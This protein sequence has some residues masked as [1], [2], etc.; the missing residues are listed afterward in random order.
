MKRMIFHIPYKIDYNRPSGTNI[1][2]QKLIRAFKNIGYEVELVE[3][4]G[5]ER[6]NIIKEIKKKIKNG[7]KYEFLYSESST[8]PTLLT[9]KHHLPIYPFL[10]FNFI[11][12]CKKNGIKIGLFYRDI[13]WNF[14]Q[15]KVSY[16][17]KIISK[18]FYKYDLRIYEDLLNVLFLPSKEMKKYIPLKKNIEVHESFPGIETYKKIRTKNNSKIKLF[19]VGGTGDLYDYKLLLKVIKGFSDMT[20]S[21][22]TRKE[23]WDCFIKK[24]SNIEIKENIEIAHFSGEEMEKFAENSDLGIL[25]VNP[26]KYWEFAVPLKL[27]QY[28]TLNIPVLASNGTKV[29]K[30]INEY[31][32]GWSIGYSEYELRE[33][34][35]KI[36][37]NRDIIEEKRKNVNS[38][39]FEHT[40]ESRAKKIE[41]ELTK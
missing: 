31:D 21:I 26:L 23:E 39:Y 8:M 16:I 12:L 9:E 30:I 6:K 1:R 34:L 3:G 38:I 19:Y 41:K 28:L 11:K 32:I 7:I 35:I 20:F 4:Y 24:N 10:D 15:Y 14:E 29:G 27:F 36:C 17:K 37:K 40:W 22:C 13:H 2:P 5:K 18:F 25:Y 33:M